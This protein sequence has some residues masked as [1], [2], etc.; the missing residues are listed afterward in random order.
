MDVRRRAKRGDLN[1]P[2]NLSNN[3]K[4]DDRWAPLNRLNQAKGL[5]CAKQRKIMKNVVFWDVTPCGC[6]KNQRFGGT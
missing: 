3:P 1:L 2:K 6:C 4:L 5:N